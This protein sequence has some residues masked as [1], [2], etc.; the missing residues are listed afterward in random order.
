MCWWNHPP[1]AQVY[2][3]QAILQNYYQGCQGLEVVLQ[4]LSGRDVILE[5]NTEVG[6]V[7]TANIVPSI[8]IPSNHNLSENKNVQ[9][10]SA[11]ADLSGVI[12]QEE[13]NPENIL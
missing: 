5:P 6:M 10:K 11:Q 1:I 7:T 8:Q 12:Q 9:Y 2:S 3:F 13:T 4:N